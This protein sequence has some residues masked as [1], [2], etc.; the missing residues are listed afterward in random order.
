MK[1]LRRAFAVFIAIAAAATAAAGTQVW[2]F[3]GGIDDWEIANGDWDANNGVLQQTNGTTV[4][5]HAI[6]GE[7]DWD[8]YVVETKIRID[9]GNW[10]GLIFRAQ[11]VFQYYV[12]YLNV[13]D[14]KS[15]L[16]KHNPGGFDQRN[17]LNSNIGAEG[18]QVTQGEWIHVKAELDGGKFAL[19]INDKLQAEQTEATHATGAIGL[20]SWRTKASFDDLTITGDNV[21]DTLSVQPNGKLASQWA[22]LKRR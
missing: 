18:V 13:P 2:D 14:N 17:A 4:A 8:D 7:T 19:Y 16:W 10:A 20:W 3:S 22:A 21:E 9:E 15:E 5:A 6:V 1:H 12:Y 11:D